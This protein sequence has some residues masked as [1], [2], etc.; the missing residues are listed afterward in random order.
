MPYL[1]KKQRTGRASVV[2]VVISNS[3]IP[4]HGYNLE[5]WKANENSEGDA[6]VDIM[7]ELNQNI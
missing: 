2:L 6:L 4:L 5:V 1:W 7:K 3:S